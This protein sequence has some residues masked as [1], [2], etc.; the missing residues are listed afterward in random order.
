MRRPLSAA[1]VTLAVLALLASCSPS[2]RPLVQVGSQ[3]VTV[4]DYE[5]AA[6]GAEAQ[7]TGPPEL[8]K[9][10]L[11]LDLQRRA[12]MLELAH[13][14]GYDS[15]TVAAAS[16]RNNERRA[17]VQ[18]FFARVASPVQRVSEA[19]A[20][21]LYDARNQEAEVW[22]IYTSSRQSSLGALAR[23][24]AGAPFADVSRSLSLPGVLP[25]DGN[26]GTVQP[27]S[28]PDPLDGA[29]RN[30]PVGKIG[31]P[32]ETREGWF[33]VKIASRR[34]H[35]QGAWEALRAGMF[36][37]ER[38]RKQRAAFNRAYT[39]LKAEW[40][41]QAAPGGAQMLFRVTSP[42]EPLKPTPAQRSMPLTTYA[43]G[44]YT[45]Q[46]ALD[47]MA[48]ASLQRPPAQLLPA[49]EIWIEAQTMTRIAALE[50]R[51]RHLNEEP[52]VLLPLRRKHE[53]A[54]LEGVYQIAV[55]AVPPPGP[56]QVQLAW[57]Q[58]KGRFTHISDVHVV[59]VVL[60]DSSQIMKLV[61]AGQQSHQLADAAKAVSP[62]LAILD[63]TVNYPNNDPTW[64]AM[65]A[66]FTQL[67]PGSW[68]GPESIEGGW[69]VIQLINKTV[70]QQQFADLPPATQQNITSSAA[71]LARNTR[72]E[73]F[74]DSLARAYKP[75]VD[76]ALLAKL[77]WPVKPPLTVGR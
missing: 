55:A 8:A 68:Y 70:V 46:D 2:S 61:H 34:P 29:V 74:T 57:E 66:L 15:S 54:L 36:D 62:T 11:T 45:L 73:Q 4:A 25:P 52:E 10:Q 27:G 71:E 12:T 41:V 60:T 37:L 26:M 20:R 30:L 50:A 53:D 59:S 48:D 24:Q 42:V 72:F 69:K 9:A 51:R 49:L 19:E 77:P 21:A 13:R 47:D 6:Q 5:R 44:A 16:D 75:Q 58:L 17:L 38:Q 64:N 33:L 35:E 76:R 32:Y 39:D 31:G 28:L 22:L 23:L 56:E 7:Y 18:E 1:G 65:L 14:L 43:G 67:Q 3:T 40:Q 63:T